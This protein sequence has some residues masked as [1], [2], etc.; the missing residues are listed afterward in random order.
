MGW[1]LGQIGERVGR[2]APVGGGLE[3][4]VAGDLRGTADG[5]TTVAVGDRGGWQRE[6]RGELG[7]AGG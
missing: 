6:H 7:P 5:G 4:G 2:W 1:G 3:L